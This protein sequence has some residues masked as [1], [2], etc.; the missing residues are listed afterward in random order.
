MSP[1]LLGFGEVLKVSCR[2]VALWALRN[3]ATSVSMIWICFKVEL[4]SHACT[5]KFHVGGSAY[6][7]L[8]VRLDHLFFTRPFICKALFLFL[9]L[10]FHK[11]KP[12]NKPLM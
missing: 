3:L 10:Y 9:L 12:Q 6:T 5:R 11:Y 1:K 2:G 8:S 7:S 4:E